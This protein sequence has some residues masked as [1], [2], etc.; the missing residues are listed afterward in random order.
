M[1]NLTAPLK[2][3]LNESEIEFFN[4]YSQCVFR[5]CAALGGLELSTDLSPPKS[6]TIRAR[7]LKEMGQIMDIY[8]KPIQLIKDTVI[9]LNRTDA[10]LLIRQGVLQYLG[11]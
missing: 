3:K 6:T 1:G 4:K 9:T 5:Y 7:V 11:D 8:G 10:E 2:Q